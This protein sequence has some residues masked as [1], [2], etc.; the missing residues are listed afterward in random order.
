MREK[1]AR[2]ENQIKEEI[3]GRE[4]EREEDMEEETGQSG[5]GPQNEVE[6]REEDERKR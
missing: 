3:R 4:R 2:K 1:I 5:R 6:K